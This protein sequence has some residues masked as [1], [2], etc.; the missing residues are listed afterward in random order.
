LNATSIGG[1]LRANPS[2]WLT[3][4]ID[5]VAL[6]NRALEPAEITSLFQDGTPVPF[7][8]AQ[9]LAVRSFKAD[10]PAV[11]VGDSVT[12]RWD[13]TKNVKVEIDRGIGDVTAQ[14]V[15]G[16]G[17]IEVTLPST[18]TFNMTLT[19]GEETVSQALTVYAI[20]GVAEGWT[21]IDNFDRYDLGLL[22]GQGGWGDLDAADFSVIEH[23]WK[24]VRRTACRRSHRRACPRS[25]DHLRRPATHVVLPRLSRG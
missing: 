15:A 7:T 2:H 16:L 21:L 9:P 20:D 1:I 5:D 14:T 17:S 22:N 25:A 11:A 19:R 6:W 8:K 23:E 24:P 18:R 13:V 12:L 10:F 3:G 4:T